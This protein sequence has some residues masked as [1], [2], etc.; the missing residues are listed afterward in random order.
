[1]L[2][3]SPTLFEKTRLRE[4]YLQS[5]SVGRAEL[6]KFAE[7][8]E[9]FHDVLRQFPPQAIKWMNENLLRRSWTRRNDFN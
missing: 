4:K 1:M 6:S 8:H 7:H 3:K 2:H 9:V 5:L